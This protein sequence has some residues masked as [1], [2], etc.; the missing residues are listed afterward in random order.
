MNFGQSNED[1]RFDSGP[2]QWYSYNANSA[3]AYFEPMNLNSQ[4]GREHYSVPTEYQPPP[5]SHP[6]QN[7]QRDQTNQGQNPHNNYVANRSSAKRE[8]Q[9]KANWDQIYQIYGTAMA[10]L[11]GRMRREFHELEITDNKTQRDEWFSKEGLGS[12]M[13][14][15]DSL[16]DLSQTDCRREPEEV[17]SIIKNGVHPRKWPSNDDF[18]ATRKKWEAARKKA[19]VIVNGNGW[20]YSTG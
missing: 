16:P 8:K 14:W 15:Y 12:L 13:T 6:F 11:L 2:Q 10:V 19:S 5:S 7:V 20:Q 9:E 3:G 17:K 1:Y 4:Q 18:S